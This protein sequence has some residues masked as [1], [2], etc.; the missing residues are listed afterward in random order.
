M[1][2]RQL[3]SAEID[4]LCDQFEAQC[5]SGYA[6][7]VEKFIGDLEESDRGLLLRELL[8]IDHQY[9]CRQ[10][11][12]PSGEEYRRRFPEHADLIDEV[13][14]AG[15]GH[16]ADTR[17]ESRHSAA[18]ASQGTRQVA[19]TLLEALPAGDGPASGS[20]TLGDYEVLD[21]IGRGGM[22]L[23]FR[24]RQKSVDRLVALKILRRDK[25]SD[26][27][28]DARQMM[29][30]RFRTESQSAAQLDHDHIVPVYDVGEENGL[31]YYS[32]RLVQ[33]D[34][35]ADK[36]NERPLD[37]HTAARL[38][39][40]IARALHE[41]HA[42]GVL[43][44]DIKPRNVIIDAKSG[45]PLLTD[46]GLAKM[47]ESESDMTR[48][49]DVMGSPPYMSPEQST[50]AASVTGAAD[51]YSLG[52]MM[53]HVLTG[54]PPF[55]AATVSETLRQVL[56]DDPIPLRRLNPA[57]DRDL[58]TICLKCLEKEPQR[59]F[60]TAGELAD[61]LARYLRGEP[62]RSRPLGTIG[63]LRRWCRRRPAVA[64]LVATVAVLLVAIAAI[65]I[66]AYYREA[67]NRRVAERRLGRA[68]EAV[69]GLTDIATRDDG[70]KAHG[71]DELRREI[72]GKSRDYYDRFVKEE[73]G[74]P[75][76][77]VEQGKAYGRLANI[78]AD[79]GGRDEAVRLYAQ[80]EAVFER[81]QQRFPDEPEYARLKAAYQANRAALY[82]DQDKHRL[83]NE[84]I[85]AAYA[86]AKGLADRYPQSTQIVALLAHI[87]GERAVV[88]N[89]LGQRD[90]AEQL[91]L[92]AT[93]HWRQ[94]TESRGDADDFHR[95]AESHHNLAVFY[96]NS[97]R[98]DEA[99]NH[100]GT[101]MVIWKRLV[102]QHAEISL[103]AAGLATCQYNLGMLHLRRGQLDDAEPLLA[104][105]LALRKDL[106]AKHPK[107]LDYQDHLAISHDGLGQLFQERGEFD[108]AAQ[109]YREG[110]FIRESLH[111]EMGELRESVPSYYE[112]NMA[113][114]QTNLGYLYR[115][116]EKY[117]EAAEYFRTALEIL[118][119][120]V[121]ENRDVVSHRESLAAVHHN[122][123]VVLHLSDDLQQAE[124]HAGRAVQLRRELLDADRDADDYRSALAGSLAKLAQ[125]LQARQKLSEAVQ[126]QQEAIEVRLP[127]A[128]RDNVPL[129][130]RLSL[131]EA[132]Y[133][134]GALQSQSNNLPDA[135]RS[136]SAAIDVLRPAHAA[137]DGFGAARQMLQLSLL[138]RCQVLDA[139]GQ[140]DRAVEDW[141]AVLK[142]CAP[143]Q[144][145]LF[146]LR[147]AVSQARGGDHRAAA[148]A[149]DPLLRLDESPGELRFHAACVLS[150]AAEAAESDETLAPDARQEAATAYLDRAVDVLKKLL[151][152][153]PAAIEADRLRGEADLRRLWKHEPAR[154][155]LEH[156]PRADENEPA[157]DR[158][159]AN[160]AGG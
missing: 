38:I 20:P 40:P 5:K 97:G 54:R 59:R 89:D 106:A 155:L 18:G 74:G 136:F 143:E 100:F 69:D 31:H 102:D 42:V 159:E 68:V 129:P 95:H 45:R 65:S 122:L 70:L 15:L 61:E 47:V 66:A 39:E 148:A 36:I 67:H 93:G 37:N 43:H 132:H 32:M 127:L 62:I 99:A 117:A 90:E 76:L 123:A 30:D 80:A 23:V 6:P 144:Q 41:A 35:L 9:R 138:A 71:L 128:Q 79:L 34:S 21:E 10:G 139:Q 81:M 135:A 101:A 55:Q 83:A 14:S 120:I 156:K 147:R 150:R 72:L 12:P 145:P 109:A 77:E 87:Q 115:E 118:D 75:E 152:D 85:D 114:S 82:R 112:A 119:R 94:I 116:H 73:G 131:G 98:L 44:R 3:T 158:R 49:G 157:E 133:R 134:L 121:A 8:F 24:A 22:G 126:R 96:R 124:V 130:V 19:E 58:E 63:H 25:L 17:F 7:A 46:F 2:P 57:I 28:P 142:L 50:N 113:A 125:V 16:G 149:V 153:E 86:Q 1:P 33:G 137:D 107:V 26:L 84:T 103:Y 27:A 105:A 13:L 53:Y 52:A 88:L 160:A 108:Q 154:R 111:R 104:R 29:V 78:E 92:A 141:D 151:H 4:E 51:I 48:T 146:R 60:A 91:W 140:H 56:M 110:L 64:A 11:D